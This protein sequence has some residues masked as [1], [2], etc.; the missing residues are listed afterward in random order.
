MP[1]KPEQVIAAVNGGKSVKLSDGHSLYMVSAGKGIGSWVF[2]YRDGGKLTSKG[3]GS[4]H[5]LSPAAARR[6]RDDFRVKVRRGEHTPSVRSGQPSELR[7][8]TAGPS[9]VQA[10]LAL[11]T[12]RASD[13][14]DAGEH[15]KSALR[16]H[17]GAI[18][19]RTLRT[20]T[21]EQV[22]DVL[23]SGW[24]GPCAGGKARLRGFLEAVFA[25]ADISPNPAS[26]ERLRHLLPND[27]IETTHH[28]ALPSS[29]IP[30][31][32][33]ELDA[34]DGEGDPNK[35]EVARCL[36]FCILTATRTIEAVEMDWSEVSSEWRDQSCED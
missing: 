27:T 3:L 30:E 9:L 34:W 25:A 10:A 23:R 12:N 13:W 29:D 5:D 16:N 1:L 17:C 36:R 35:R 18:A 33:A 26:W 7:R 20:V 2:Q 31:L 19:D 21:R 22:A 6:A 15:H 8:E 24:R 32:M 28:E 14:K 11:L 4:T